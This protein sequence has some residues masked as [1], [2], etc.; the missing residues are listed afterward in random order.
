M[1]LPVWASFFKVHNFEIALDK[2]VDQASTNGYDLIGAAHFPAAV[3][4]S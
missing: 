3:T 4:E 2:Q 1:L